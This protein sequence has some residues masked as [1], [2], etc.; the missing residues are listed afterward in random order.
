[1][2]LKAR[3]SRLCQL[4]ASH[5]FWI[6]AAA[7]LPFYSWISFDYGITWDEWLDANN[8]LLT[9]RF[10]LSWGQ[11][12]SYLQFWHGY[13]YSGLFFTLVG[14]LY[15]L[16][17]GS[18]HELAY[19]GLFGDRHILPFFLMSH[20]VNGLFGW[21]AVLFTG[22]TAKRIA[23]WRAGLIGL[24][25]GLLCPRFFGASFND[26]KDI[27]MAAG[28][29]AALYYMTGIMKEMPF[30]KKSTCA[31]AAVSIAVAIGCR[32]S[33]L[34]LLPYLVLF[35]GI[36]WITASRGNRMP[37][38]RFSLML[39]LTGSAG[40]FG[41]LLCWPYALQNPLIN[42]YLALKQFS[43]FSSFWNGLVLFE[44]QLIEASNLPWYTLIKW[45][46]I[47]VPLFIH[48]GVILLLL[49]LKTLCRLHDWRIIGAVTFAFLFPLGYQIVTDSTVYDAWRHF[50]F[51]YPPL[52]VLC[53]L[54]WNKV[55]PEP[56]PGRTFPVSGILLA[57]LLALPLGWMIKNHPHQYT[58]YNEL[59][60]GLKG[61]YGRYETDYW[62]NSLRNCAEAL[63]EHHQKNEPQRKIQ[64]RAD[65]SLMSTYPFLKKHLGDLYHP[66]LYPEGFLKR[67][68]YSNIRYSNDLKGPKDWDYAI[69]MPRGSSPE[70]L[71]SG[72]WPPPET[73]YTEKADG[74]PLCAVVKNS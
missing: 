43:Q 73:L 32:A 62:G 29:I 66:Y 16:L 15:G 46:A 68:P 72:A 34:L 37:F 12:T 9:I 4:Q 7:L 22:L 27:P 23:G 67:F 65:G 13:L 60:G 41:G 1:M 39:L 69:I 18:V 38:I 55:L 42:P 48:A 24:A 64:V 54:A 47:S 28:Y 10:I 70:S 6:I 25:M 45:I 51:V 63:A 50:Y 30:P 3:L 74:V 44:G 2:P 14:T 20:W 52:A 35:S 53:A 19:G 11:D 26:P 33:G 58:Y 21:A 71:R 59:V 31:G 5:L 17:S 36:A 56:S 8:I 57:L 49:N 40:Y 61:A